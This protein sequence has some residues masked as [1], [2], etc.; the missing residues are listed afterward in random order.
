MAKSL[1]IQLA[2]RVRH[3]LG[4]YFD[5]T[6]DMLPATRTQSPVDAFLADLRGELGALT[7]ELHELQRE[8]G[9]VASQ[10]NGLSTG[11]HDAIK[12]GREDLAQAAFEEQHA[13]RERLDEIETET[14]RLTRKQATLSDLILE[15]SAETTGIEPDEAARSKKLKEFLS[16]V[17]QSGRGE[18]EH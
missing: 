12:Q 17:Q 2:D 18:G 10:L 11:T 3:E 1:L 16:L 13:L 15:F 14:E 6:G 8:R 9:T 4:E 7:V 5:E